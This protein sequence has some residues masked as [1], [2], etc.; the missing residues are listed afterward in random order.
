[1]AMSPSTWWDNTV[2]IGDVSKMGATRPLKAYVDSGDSGTS[3]DDVT[4]T[5]NLAATF[6]TVGYSDGST[7]DYLVQAGGQHNEVYWAERLPG[8]LQFLF[9]P[10]T[11]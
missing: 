1:G 10:R 8:A 7:L 11:P 2:I 5:A 9:G 3:N 4:D 6:R